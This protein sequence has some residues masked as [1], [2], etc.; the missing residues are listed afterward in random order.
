V[1]GEEVAHDGD[2]ELGEVS[3]TRCLMSGSGSVVSGNG[4]GRSLRGRMV[5]M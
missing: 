3:K 4:H 5:S 1:I 2:M